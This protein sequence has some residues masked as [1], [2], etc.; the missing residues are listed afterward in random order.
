MNGKLRAE[1]TIRPQSPDVTIADLRAKLSDWL[2]HKHH[3]NVYKDIL[4]KYPIYDYSFTTSKYN[5]I[6][7]HCNTK[8]KQFLFNEEVAFSVYLLRYTILT[9]PLC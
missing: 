4:L 2:L 8:I 7:L 5:G 3:V 1:V 6:T 9:Y